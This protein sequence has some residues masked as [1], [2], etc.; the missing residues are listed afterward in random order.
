MSIIIN[1]VRE[2]NMK[3]QSCRIRVLGAKR[4]VVTIP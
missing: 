4:I 1:N 2:N 3:L